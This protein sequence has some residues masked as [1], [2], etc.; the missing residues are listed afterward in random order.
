MDDLTDDERASRKAWVK[1][2]FYD[3]AWDR[4]NA[5]ADKNIRVVRADGVCYVYGG[6]HL[7]IGCFKNEAQLFENL[8]LASLT[9][10]IGVSNLTEIAALIKDNAAGDEG[11][12]LPAA[13]TRSRGG[14]RARRQ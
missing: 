7:A 6:G 10:D 12:P 9:A 8:L 13:P 11:S 3:Y 14:G 1:A 5:L 4:W 2:G